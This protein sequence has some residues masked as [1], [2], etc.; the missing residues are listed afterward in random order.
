MLMSQLGENW[1]QCVLAVFFIIAGSRSNFGSFKVL[2]YMLF[3][4]R[5]IVESDSANAILWASKSEDAP[6]KFHF[7][8]QEIKALS[9][10]DD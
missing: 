9:S 2:F 3:K 5:F 1:G 10:N 6:W 4:G 8:L 7:L